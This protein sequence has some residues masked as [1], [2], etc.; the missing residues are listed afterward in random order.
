MT[1]SF[2]CVA[3]PYKG[4]TGGVAWNG[5]WI[6]FSAVQEERILRYD[7]A[8]GAVDD[9]RRYT[10]RTN[11]IATAASGEVF[12]AQEG[13]RRVIHFKADGSTAPTCDLLD[14]KHHNQPTDIIVDKQG[15]VWFTDPHNPVAP[16]GPPV[17]PF[18]EHGSVLRLQRGPN[19]AWTL[20]R[21]TADTKEPRALLLSADEKNLFVGEGNAEMG[22]RCQLRAYALDA[23]GTAGAC[24]VLYEFGEGERGIEGMAL[25]SEGHVIACGG[26]KKSGS[27]PAIFVFAPTG[28]LLESQGAPFDLPMRCAFGGRDMVTLFVTSGDGRLYRCDAGGRRGVSRSAGAA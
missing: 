17:Y 1:W 28:E 21:I 3:G 22:G 20:N 14:G 25:D 24:K 13:G 6:L 26:W 18:L 10:G 19:G 5:E 7:P 9:F 2:D 27:G 8:T 12:G 4:I 16:Y 15:R 11:G 23:N